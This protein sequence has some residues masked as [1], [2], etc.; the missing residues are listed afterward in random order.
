MLFETRMVM[1]ASSDGRVGSGDWAA[2]LK[3]CLVG[4]VGGDGR[5]VGVEGPHCMTLYVLAAR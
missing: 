4:V 2:L 3:F 5:P 1:K